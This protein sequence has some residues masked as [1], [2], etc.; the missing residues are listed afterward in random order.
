MYMEE[1]SNTQTLVEALIQ[2]SSQSF[3]FHGVVA[4]QLFLSDDLELPSKVD[5]CVE[6]KKLIDIVKAIPKHF[7]VRFFNKAGE[8]SESHNMSLKEITHTNVY[9]EEQQI[10]EIFV[11]DV[12]ND[13]WI[14]RLN[15]QIRLPKN[16]IYFHSL[17]YDVDYIKPEIVLM[18]D[19]LDNQNYHQFSNYKKV[20]DSLSYYQF[21]ILKLVVGEK[22]IKEAILNNKKILEA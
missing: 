21:F 22:R 9:D 6:R 16:N 19:L 20:I 3:K 2:S 10:M 11:Y 8:C 15:S 4:M 5:I 14:F 18:Y 12:V 7:D 17:N 13:E 1:H